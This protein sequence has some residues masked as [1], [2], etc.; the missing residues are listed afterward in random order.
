M[1]RTRMLKEQYDGYAKELRALQIKQYREIRDLDNNHNNVNS[2]I[3]DLATAIV[4]ET[5]H[6]HRDCDSYEVTVIDD[7]VYV[8]Q[9]DYNGDVCS[10][11]KLNWEELDEQAAK[12][13]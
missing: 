12:V 10:C 2:T 4:K 6:V 9:L 13:Q 8:D 11:N 1:G 7:T 3:E 5:K